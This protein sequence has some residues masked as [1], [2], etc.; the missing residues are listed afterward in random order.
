[1]ARRRA[2]E[3]ADTV[4]IEGR[5]PLMY[6]SL[7]PIAPERHSATYLK[8]ERDY[9]VASNLN[10]VPVTCDEFAQVLRHYPIVLAPGKTPTPVALVGLRQGKNDHVGEDGKWADGHYIPAYLRRYPFML[11]RESDTSDRQILC[12]DFTSTLFTN[13]AEQGR[14]MFDADG[15]TSEVLTGILDFCNRFEAAQQRTQ[16]VM[17]EAIDLDLVQPS[18]VN[19]SR[20]GKT[21]RIEGFSMIAEDRVRALPDDKLAD[22]ARRGLLSIFASHHLSMANFSDIGALE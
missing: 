14:A 4:D 9:S 19:V 22:L 10:A 6:K 11:L 16:Q 13:D 15:G 12:A 8:S 3:K 2:I 20:G 1:M 17:Q 5:L 18:T 7:G 21:A